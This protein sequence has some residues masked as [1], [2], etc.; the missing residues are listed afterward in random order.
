MTTPKNIT[1]ITIA[2]VAIIVLATMLGTF[3]LT[4][5]AAEDLTVT[6][7]TGE[8]VTLKDTDSD[9]Y[10][11]I[12]TADELYAFAAAVADG[13]NSIGVKLTAN[14]T[15]NEGVMTA[16]STGV[17]IWT[18]ITNS[19]Y[20]TFD[21]DG[22]TVSGLYFN[23][24]S[25][26]DVGL[27]GEIGFGS[28][29]LNVGVINSYFSGNYYVG[30]IVGRSF[31]IIENCYNASA[32]HGVSAYIGGVVGY[33]NGKIIK[34]CYNT[35]TITNVDGQAGGVAGM[36]LDGATIENCYNT[37]DVI[38]STSALD[39]PDDLGGVVGVINNGSMLNCY[40]TGDVSGKNNVGGVVGSSGASVS[41]C[42]NTGNVSGEENV[43][44]VVGYDINSIGEG[45]TTTNCYNTGNVKG[46]RYVGG[47]MGK[48]IT[49]SSIV[50]NCY[51]LS[52]CAKDGSSTVQ[53][54]IGAATNGSTT[55]DVSGETASV[56]S[57]QLQS[58]EI[59]SRLGT[60][61]GQRIDNGVVDALPVFAAEDGSNKV[62]YGYEDC[63]DDTPEYTNSADPVLYA[64]KPD[65]TY[66]N[67]ICSECNDYSEP[68]VEASGDFAD[69]YKIENAGQ[70]YWF[71]Q[72]VNAGNANAKAYLANNIEVNPGLSAISNDHKY[73]INLDNSPSS[74]Y[75]LGT[76][77]GG[78][79]AG[80]FYAKQPDGTYVIVED[81]DAYNIERIREL[82]ATY[83][84]PWTPIGNYPNE[85]A[86]TFN[87]N[88]YTVSGL[89]FNDTSV[90]YVGL[91]GY[92]RSD[93]KVDKVEVIN[94]FF[95]GKNY[96]GGVAG[97]NFGS[98][99]N[100]YST[101][102]VSGADY[103]GGVA[104]F[105]SGSVE[106]S[107]N[108][109]IVSG[110][111]CVGGVAGYNTNSVSNCYNTGSVS[112]HDES[113][114][115]GTHGG[116][117]GYNDG[118]TV[119]NSYNTG[120]VNGGTWCGGGV[121]GFFC[122]G[123]VSNC[124]NVGEVSG[125]ANYTGGVIGYALSGTV[126][127][128]YFYKADSAS[129]NGIGYATS[130][131]ISAVE[132]KNADQFA[133]G[134]V[135]NLL[136]NAF[137]QTI[138]TDD[139]PVFRTESNAVYKNQLGGCDE[140]TFIYEYSN[141]SAEPVTTHLSYN[142]NGFCGCGTTYQPA[143][144][145]ADG[146]YEIDN[147]GKLYWFAAQ[148]NGGATDISGILTAD[149]TVN[150]GTMTEKTANARLWTPIG[151]STN[152]YTGIFNG[153]GHTVSGLYFNDT[154]MNYIGMFGYLETNG[155]V[156]NVGVIN[157][158][159]YG[160]RY[161]G[162]LV[163][164]NYGTVENCYNTGTVKGEYGVGGVVGYNAD[165]VENCYNT[166]TVKGEISVGGIVGY[167]VSIVKNCYNTGNVS[168]TATNVGGVGGFNIGRVKNCFYLIGCAKDGSNV[169]Q[170]GIGNETRGST[171]EDTENS[172]TAKTAEQFES[173]EVAYL[174][175]EAFGQDVTTG[176]NDTTVDALP[177]FAAADGSNKLYR[178][179]TGE[180]TSIEYKYAN[181]ETAHQVVHNPYACAYEEFIQGNDGAFYCKVEECGAKA[182][183]SVT[184]NGL[185]V[186]E[187]FTTLADAVNYA[188]NET[189][190][191]LTLLESIELSDALTIMEGK[192]TID[193]NGNTLSN[194]N[195]DVIKITNVANITVTSGIVGG[196]I[197]AKNACVFVSK[198]IAKVTGVALNS[199]AF[200]YNAAAANGAE[201][202]L[203]L[204]N[205]TV[206]AAY[207]GVTVANGGRVEILGNS[208]ISGDIYDIACMTDSNLTLGKGVTFPGGLTA[209]KANNY[210]ELKL[211]CA[212]GMA[213]W[214]GENQMTLFGPD[215]YEIAGDVT[216]REA[217][218]HSDT[219]KYTYAA[220][221]ATIT[222]TCTNCS[223]TAGTSTLRLDSGNLTY[224]GV[225]KELSVRHDIGNGIAIPEIVCA[226]DLTSAGS[227]TA[228]I[229]LGGATATL[230]IEIEKATLSLSDFVITNT[231][232]EYALNTEQGVDVELP[233]SL[234]AQYV[235]VVYT[236]SGS[237]ATPKDAGIY[238]VYIKV[239]G[240][241]NYNDT[242]VDAGQFTINPRPVVNIYVGK[243]NEEFFYNG[244]EIE[245]TVTVDLGSLPFGPK[246]FGGTVSYSN[247]IN[248]GEATVTLGG[249]FT[250][251]ATFEIKKATPTI[252]VSAPLDKVMPG[253]VMDITAVTG[254]VD[255][256]LKP[257]T[258][259][260]V[261]GEGYSVSGK[262]ITIDE[263]V[264][265]GST[266]TVKVTST[267]TDNYTAGEGTLTLTVGIPTVDT[268][269][270]ETALEAL[271]NRVN[272][273]ENKHG[274]D[275]EIA[276]IKDDIEAIE[277]ALSGYATDAELANAVNRIASLETKT[278]EI[279]TAYAKKAD[280]DAAIARLE[281]LIAEK[282]DADEIAA[283]INTINT[284]LSELTDAD[285]ALDGRLDKIEAALGTLIDE[286]LPT[287]I[288]NIENDVDKN[289]SDI[290]AIN[291]A[292]GDLAELVRTNNADLGD[293]I[294]AMQTEIDG[295]LDRMAKAEADIAKI[296]EDLAKAVADLNAADLENANEIASEIARVEGL[297]DAAE[298]A[299]ESANGALKTELENAIKTADDAIKQLIADLEAKLDATAADIRTKLEEAVID[300]EEA[301][302]TNTK[303]IE[304]AVKRIEE[305][306]AQAKALG[307]Q[308]AALETAMNK[309]DEAI[310]TKITELKTKLDEA[311]K[312][313][314]DS[315]LTNA[316]NLASEIKRVEGLID[317]AEALV[318]STSSDLKNELQN[319]INKADS[320]LDE[321]IKKVAADLEAAEKELNDKISANDSK[322]ESEIAK[323]NDTITSVRT[324]LESADA[325]NKREL[326][327]A[328]SSAQA[329]LNSAIN[330]VASALEEAKTELYSAI[331]SGDKALE[332]KISSLNASLYSARAAL[333]AAD[334]DNKAE[335]TAKIET[336]DKALDDAIKAVQKNLDDAK[337]ELNKAIADGDKALDDKITA[338]NTALDTAK[339]ALEKANADSKA[340]L[341]AKIDSANA[342]LDAAI[343]KLTSELADAK[344]SLEAKDA[345]IEEKLDAA[346]IAISSAA[347]IG[348]SGNVALLVW[349]ILLKRKRSL[350]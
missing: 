325:E 127:N 252:T 80:A 319:T 173:G 168:G 15:V 162:G 87:G 116:V 210:K 241:P 23:D 110:T 76:G 58:G 330:D 198:G 145:N 269:E 200:R 30:G 327:N 181:V 187:Y 293:R 204:E 310:N 202:V 158:Y 69:Y 93:G 243:V 289:A 95:S 71:A 154:S 290:T 320:A 14:I 278:A 271:K 42:Y 246:E 220:E 333:E 131:T 307:E 34:N 73:I 65:H 316:E 56:T 255:N 344:S 128:C 223:C 282:A 342:E 68:T 230:T 60:A 104:G 240:S 146:V 225:K 39:D 62:Y 19:Y 153:D 179:G 217:C 215:S 96:V 276:A 78:T 306:E 209:F 25:A 113:S 101:G 151:D 336:A 347:G 40:N 48:E 193:L 285:T 54:G 84:R 331:S 250:G 298:A 177:V 304:A 266:I 82:S 10:Y 9:G 259:T 107:Y 126:N 350:L 248:V 97:D 64:E 256:F 147:A 274:E 257:T 258:F 92:V 166:G 49:N 294:D 79:T 195:G 242:E 178:Y 251:S 349:I 272:E 152:K 143:T 235:T 50:D 305:L 214:T 102:V 239:Q 88:G 150:E 89:Y 238:S 199:T 221:G 2:L 213:Y 317:A 324:I 12:G 129:Y 163:G 224:D 148:V 245:P 98:V 197:E 24:T 90:N 38:G 16:E 35:G 201:A 176:E 222:A 231:S 236:Q 183:A 169:V 122:Q 37:G 216:V 309:A 315:D 108:I 161:V 155:K 332:N 295:I 3:T 171:T 208:S 196:K 348:I 175:G 337:A 313:L 74:D 20:G 55:A 18:P 263:G 63:G 326:R 253:Y 328:I 85:Y 109:G 8:S 103:V 237:P 303:A 125:S 335:L 188:K 329:T 340:E 136:G 218:I 21:G 156:Q 254:A 149:I 339:S 244:S 91:F 134:E 194:S 132:S 94:S 67:G 170:N 302:T 292:L 157:S 17:R 308:D 124:Y 77:I 72:Y 86:G 11:E 118:G 267:A 140:A 287:L 32:I 115:S 291:T 180:C 111:E 212:D 229:T 164:R 70:L 117:V 7:D 277:F 226:T 300:L 297:I 338:L 275:G 190:S 311:I 174:L 59:A 318:Q 299:A 165:T 207:G 262:T 139:I 51:Y 144:L 138:G 203:T 284:K 36:I 288:E 141:T 346:I 314:S 343:K 184:R 234:D 135:A 172:T 249:N 105:N 46:Y 206:T 112:V 345:E 227:H 281:G 52:G 185:T 232:L 279:E 341:T 29:V 312:D 228:S 31:G 45:G 268:A 191:T 119:K 211:L 43:G 75:A 205:V 13:K 44:G 22:H 81:T 280:L 130:T 4:S 83:L 1:K 133:R 57:E 273:L 233:D 41:N 286:S 33:Q 99:E 301:D 137:G 321:A 120:A 5:F 192:F 106:K 142:E 270:L 121:V 61:F 167:N 66:T 47:I 6:I 247:N 186:S 160:K 322:L 283:Q 182:I 264:K 114:D 261:D 53:N 265:I 219:A 296:K 100:S 26:E 28:K 323:L 159:F 27:F 123:A 260:V 189:D 334:E